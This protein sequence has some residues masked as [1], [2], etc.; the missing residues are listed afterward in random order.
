MDEEASAAGAC[1]GT[2]VTTVLFDRK[3]QE[4]SLLL[5]YIQ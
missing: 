1:S 3:E 4:Q 5:F 2:R